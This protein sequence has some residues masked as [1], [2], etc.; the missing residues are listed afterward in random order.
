M[1]QPPLAVKEDG[2]RTP[3]ERSR[4]SPI[5]DRLG[6]KSSSGCI[7]ADLPITAVVTRVS[8]PCSDN[9]RSWS[10]TP[11]QTQVLH[12]AVFLALAGGAEAKDEGRPPPGIFAAEQFTTRI[13]TGTKVRIDAGK[14]SSVFV[15]TLTD[16]WV[17][18]QQLHCE[19]AHSTL[20]IR[21]KKP[22]IM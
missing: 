10:L 9:F 21:V 3:W 11:P 2:L 6:A 14:C 22:R 18:S 8:S 20:C 15:N 19:L 5:L 4:Q 16:G 12:A 1:L 7:M 13:G 17:G